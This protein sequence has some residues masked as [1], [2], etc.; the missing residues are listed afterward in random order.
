MKKLFLSLLLC[1]GVLIVYAQRRPNI[2][3]AR[4][5]GFQIVKAPEHG[6]LKVEVSEVQYH[7][8]VQVY[9]CDF[10][11][12]L[13]IACREDFQIKMTT[14]TNRE[15]IITNYK[16]RGLGTIQANEFPLTIDVR[17]ME[18]INEEKYP[19]EF[20]VKLLYPGFYYDVTLYQSKQ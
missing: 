19:L 6:Y 20:T 4:R 13:P 9:L 14:S 7:D 5:T 10:P 8:F 18:L 2:L 17:V 12:S 1:F 3:D 16:R 11:R 15:V